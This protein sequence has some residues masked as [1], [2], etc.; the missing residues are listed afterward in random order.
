MTRSALLLLVSA[1]LAA[2]LLAAPPST[3]APALPTGTWHARLVPAEGVEVPFVLRVETRGGAP[4]AAVVN[5]AIESPFTSASWADGV[6]T[7][8]WTHLDAKL[9]A[10]PEGDRMAGSYV[11]IGAAGAVSVP[12]AATRLAP[13]AKEPPDGASSIDG[14]WGITLGAGEKKDRLL[15]V[16]RQAKGRVTGSALSTSG[17]Y[18]PL[19][20]TWD[21]ERLVLSVFDG[22]FIYRFDARTTEAWR[23]SSGP[24]P[25]PRFPGPPSGSTPRRRTRSCRTGTRR[26]APRTPRSRSGSPLRT[27]TERPSPPRTRA[28]RERPSW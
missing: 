18:G 14:E 27:G 15:G 12:F 21:G 20:G 28:S 3:S 22:V 11:R 7:L 2:P 13:A 6:L 25:R 19:H 9:T 4:W 23:G 17:D 5:G 26:S 16:F 24:G 8:E 10:R 1:L